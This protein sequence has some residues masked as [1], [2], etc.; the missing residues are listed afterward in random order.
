MFG[1]NEAC[2]KGQNRRRKQW[3][4]SNCLCP[5]PFGICSFVCQ[6]KHRLQVVSC[7]DSKQRKGESPVSFAMLR[8]NGVDKLEPKYAGTAG[9]VPGQ[10]CCLFCS[11]QQGL[12][13]ECIF[14]DNS[15]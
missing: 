13:T 7:L 8:V 11:E 5:P 6:D 15:C 9:T 1:R 14:H 12:T 2:D 10:P 3:P 4:C